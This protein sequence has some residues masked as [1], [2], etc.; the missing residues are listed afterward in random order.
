MWGFHF[1][2]WW[3]GTNNFLPEIHGSVCY[4]INFTR[5]KGDRENKYVWILFYCLTLMSEFMLFWHWVIWSISHHKQMSPNKTLTHE[6]VPSSFPQVSIHRT[7]W[8]NN[9]DLRL[10]WIMSKHNTGVRGEASHAMERKENELDKARRETGDCDRS[11]QLLVPGNQSSCHEPSVFPIYL[12]S[13]SIIILLRE[14]P[15][16]RCS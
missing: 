12:S 11:L 10:F 15:K 9:V 7:V 4:A 3:I 14:T 1:C 2:F 8:L 6:C 13:H 16:G 5:M